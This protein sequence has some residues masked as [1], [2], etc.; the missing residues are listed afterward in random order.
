MLRMTRRAA[1]IQRWSEFAVACPCLCSGVS[2]PLHWQC[3]R[4]AV[5]PSICVSR[6]ALPRRRLRVSR[7]ILKC[8]F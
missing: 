5:R 8:Q 3:R 6:A 4:C 7:L 1:R 2:L